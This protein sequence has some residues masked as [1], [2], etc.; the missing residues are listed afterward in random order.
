[1]GR[2]IFEGSMDGMDVY[3]YDLSQPSEITRIT[4]ELGI[5][6]K[7]LIDFPPDAQCNDMDLL[8]LTQ[9]DVPKLRAALEDQGYFAQSAEMSEKYENLGNRCKISFWD[10][11]LQEYVEF[12]QEFNLNNTVLGN[13]VMEEL[14]SGEDDHKFWSMCEAIYEYMVNNKK[15][16]Y[17]FYSET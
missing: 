7:H 9:N 12:P 3:K 14:D 1:M 13:M 5:G 4:A 2:E 6:E 15:K 8:I 16:T 17:R 10:K 11:E